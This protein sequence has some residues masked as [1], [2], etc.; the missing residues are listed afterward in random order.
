MKID[1]RYHNGGF[2]PVVAS[3]ILRLFFVVPCEKIGFVRDVALFVKI[4]DK[5]DACRDI[6]FQDLFAGQM[7]QVHDNG[8]ER[9]AVCD[10]ED[11]MAGFDIGQNMGLEVGQRPGGSVFERLALSPGGGTS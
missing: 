6:E 8:A 2:L 7:V 5:W 11:I 3:C 10:D 1:N 4:I 9:V